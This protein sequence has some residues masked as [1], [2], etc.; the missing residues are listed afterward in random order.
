MPVKKPRTLINSADT[1]KNKQARESAEAAVT[2][3]TLLTIKPP[4]ALTGHKHA[5]GIWQRLMSLYS[6]TEGTIVTAFD[7]QILITYCK[8][9]EEEINL[10]NKVS[11]L[12]KAQKDMLTKASKTK[13]TAENFKDWVSMWGEVN[14]LTKN[15]KGMDARLDGKRKHRLAL[16][17]SLYLTP[18]SRAGVPP[19]EKPPEKPKSGMGE[20]LNGDE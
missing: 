19:P 9:L 4:S 12:D 17:Q 7:E 13:P 10:E 6:E 15:F 2:P 1:K 8:I 11:E 20:L 3:K 18:R 16:E 5:S 14:T